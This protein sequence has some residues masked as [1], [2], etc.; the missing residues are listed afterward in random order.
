M[1]QVFGNY[2]RYNDD[3]DIVGFVGPLIHASNKNEVN[4]Q[5]D[6][7]DLI[8]NRS[9][10]ILM[11]DTL[12]DEKMADGIKHAENVLKIGLLYEKVDFT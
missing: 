2:L 6:D 11:G 1:L 5:N 7:Y 12:G 9:N 10:I 4:L 3:D 8:K